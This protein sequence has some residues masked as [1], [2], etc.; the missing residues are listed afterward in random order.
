M[1][2]PTSRFDEWKRR[3]AQSRGEGGGV[4]PPQ[5]QQPYRGQPQ[6]PEPYRGQGQQYGQGQPQQQQYGQG[7][8]QQY[9]GQPQQY[10]GQQYGQGQD[11]YRGQSQQQQYG[12]GQPQQYHSQQPQQAEPYRGQGRGQGQQYG[13]S[14]DQY[15]GRD[16]DQYG[17]SQQY[18]Q[19]QSQQHRD[20]PQDLLQPSYD[21]QQ[22]P[23]QQQRY[24]EVDESTARDSA[25]SRLDRFRQM[26][27]SNQQ[28][29]S[30]PQPQTQYDRGQERQQYARGQQDYSQQ[31]QYDRGQQEYNQPQYDRGQERQQYGQQPQYDRGQ[32]QSQ[33]QQPSQSAPYGRDSYRSEEGFDQSQDSGYTEESFD[34]YGSESYTNDYYAA[35]DER[36]AQA[37]TDARDSLDA[38]DDFD[39]WDDDDTEDDA[40]DLYPVRQSNFADM[41][42]LDEPEDTKVENTSDSASSGGLM[43]WLRRLTGRGSS[44]NAD[45]REAIASMN[46]KLRQPQVIGVM[47]S[48]GGVGKTSKTQIIGSILAHYRTE[49]GVAAVDMD[50]NS[51]LVDRMKPQTEI[52]DNASVHTFAHD[53]SIRS[54]ADVN[55]YLVLNEEKLA[56]LAGIGRTGSAP[57]RKDELQ[58]ILD[59][60]GEFYTLIILDFPG[61]AEVPVALHALKVIDAMI[62][63]AEITK[64]SLSATKR[65]LKRISQ[66]RPE[67]L[68]SANIILNHR[69]SGKVH[70]KNLEGHVED[71]RNMGT[72]DV[73]TGASRVKV[74][75]TNY[76]PHIGIEGPIQISQLDPVNRTR[77]MQIAA[78]VMDALPGTMPGYKRYAADQEHGQRTE[79]HELDD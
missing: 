66:V 76:D 55:S 8:P 33:Y 23:Q 77:Y 53:D 12:Q 43:G 37:V 17:Q 54:A 19:G 5:Q 25:R 65:D 59:R 73:A 39:S 14:Q 42:A 31:P 62:Y 22:Q 44:S 36:A 29:Q 41:D 67:L 35:G 46:R 18:E 27:N 63:V 4:Q 58:R 10:Q 26:Y 64:S 50:A 68:S 13:Q 57:L 71:F 2:E 16:Q 15:Q 30:Q 60:L 52:P 38:V 61:S 49:G 70:I 7:Q 78:S 24:G 47:G 3:Q 51:T 20:E 45:T 28:P 40:E 21:Q 48:K 75:E 79:V 11:Q 32:E 34:D 72:R 74:W 56:V 6:Q 1:T 69:T 9:Q